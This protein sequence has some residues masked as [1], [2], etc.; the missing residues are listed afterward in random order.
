MSRLIYSDSFQN[1]K[2]LCNIL[3]AMRLGNRPQANHPPSTPSNNVPN[4][5]PAHPPSGAIVDS[6]RRCNTVPV[7]QACTGDRLPTNQP[8]STSSGNIL[9]FPA[10][11]PGGATVNS[12]LQC[13]TVPVQQGSRDQPQGGILATPSRESCPPVRQ[14]QWAP[15]DNLPGKLAKAS[16]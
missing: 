12:N 1:N 2:D 16:T 7:Q 10:C 11:P 3:A 8:P 5:P 14:Q 15:T 4:V 13:N 9:N 6:N